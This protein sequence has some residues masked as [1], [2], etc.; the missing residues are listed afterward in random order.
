MNRRKLTEITGELE[1]ITAV[2]PE[3][4]RPTDLHPA[5]LGPSFPGDPFDQDNAYFDQYS[6][7]SYVEGVSAGHVFAILGFLALIGTIISLLLRKDSLNFM[8]FYLYQKHHKRIDVK[9][10]GKEI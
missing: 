8:T 5:E 4:Q 1:S 3:F 7:N 9:I 2:N 10:A 6:W